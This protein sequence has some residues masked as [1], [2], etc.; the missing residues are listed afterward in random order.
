M[1]SVRLPLLPQPITMNRPASIVLILLISLTKLTAQTAEQPFTL[2]LWTGLTQYNG[3]LGQGFYSGGNDGTRMHLGVAASWH[4]APRLDFSSNLTLGSWGYAEEG[5]K[6]FEAAQQQ[7]NGHFRIK[8]FTDDQ[9]PVNPFGFAGIGLSRLSKT[10]NPGTDMFIPFGFGIK[11]K[12]GKQ[13][14]LVVQETFAY[15]DHDDRDGVN[16][17]DNDA[18]MMHSIGISWAFSKEKDSDGDGVTDSK[19]RCPG[20]PAGTAVTAE[21]CPLDRDADGIADGEDRCPDQKGLAQF[22]G[23]PDR[24]A[25]GV[26]DS[27]DA[28]PDVPGL[29]DATSAG[30]GC[31]DKDKDGITDSK[32]RCPDQAGAAELEGCPDRDG[33]RVADN[34]D[35][36]PDAAGI[37]ENKGCPPVKEEVKQLFTEALQG[38]QFESAKSV[39]R[40][41]SYPIL[42]KVVQVMNEQVAYL[43]EINGHTD[44]I[45]DKTFNLE[46]SRQRAQAVKAYLESKGIQSTRLT[47]NGFGDTQPVSDNNTSTGRALNRRVEFKVKF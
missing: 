45:G 2:G 25:D 40:P 7:V 38:I 6:S 5:G 46:L 41:V 44:N 37:V 20:T 12:V 16:N 4:I 42:D 26:Q 36:C 39:I 30:K 23:C 3:D 33:D 9:H 19:D 31:P 1:S 10:D 21:G 8:L 34:D 14:H 24:D 13:L 35:K 18:F 28:C 17:R 29:A 32:D 22:R 43:L 27:D 11:T 47:A 15:T